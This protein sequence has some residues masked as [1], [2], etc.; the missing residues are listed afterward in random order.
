MVELHPGGSVINRART[1]KTGK[2]VFF[3][4]VMWLHIQ[5]KEAGGT[6]ALV[7]MSTEVPSKVHN[8]IIL[9]T[10]IVTF[11]INSKRVNMFHLII[12]EGLG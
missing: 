7:T 1:S 6:N 12:R 10:F 5:L 8:L 11:L 9:V 3:V 4:V 2:N